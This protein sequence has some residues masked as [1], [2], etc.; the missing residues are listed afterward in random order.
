MNLI[1]EQLSQHN[2]ADVKDSSEESYTDQYPLPRTWLEAVFLVG[3]VVLNRNSRSGDEIIAYDL[4][5]GRTLVGGG[6]YHRELVRGTND[7]VVAYWVVAALR[8]QRY[9]T[10]IVREIERRAAHEYPDT[11]SFIA[12]IEPRNTG[13]AAFASTL[14]YRETNDTEMPGVLVYR[15]WRE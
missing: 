5:I 11:E 2:V 4:D 9:G 13:S 15:K 8:R 14:G 10:A 12:Y 1:F 3:G 7:A 6:Q